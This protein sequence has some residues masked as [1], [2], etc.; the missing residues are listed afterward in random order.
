MSNP[1]KFTLSDKIYVQLRQDIIKQ[2]IPCGQKLTLQALKDRFNVS[3][4]PIRQA[5]TRLNE[6]GLVTYYSNC[7]VTVVT[8]T[9]EDI[10]ELFQFASELDALS[11][12]LCQYGYSSMPLLFEFEKLEEKSTEALKHN[13]INTWQGLSEDFHLLFYK[14]AKNNYLTSASKKLQSKIAL[15]SNMYQTE[16][17]I[18]KINSDHQEIIQAIRENDYEKASLLMRQHSQNDVI[19]ALKAFNML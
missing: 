18:S 2:I 15:I 13:D 6:E 4:T 14:Y 11:V 19:F 16:E 5:L 12:K 17:N 3:H 10:K 1:P 7:G 9:A 8:F